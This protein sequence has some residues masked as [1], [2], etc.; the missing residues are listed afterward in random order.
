MPRPHSSREKKQRQGKW[1]SRVSQI[2]GNRYRGRR[3]EREGE[4]GGQVYHL[5]LGLSPPFPLLIPPLSHLIPHSSPTP[6]LSPLS[7][8]VSKQVTQVTLN[9]EQS[10][11]SLL[12]NCPN[13]QPPAST[14]VILRLPLLLLL[15]PL[16]PPSSY[17]LHPTFW[18]CMH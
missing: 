4:G 12:N 2:A 10:W 17:K 11:C 8:S 5:Q 18:M 16:Q 15:P 13:F 6:P 1:P 3:G 9:K 7:P 14:L